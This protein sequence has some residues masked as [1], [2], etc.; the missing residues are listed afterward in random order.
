MAGEK[1][2]QVERAFTMS[3]ENPS[4]ARR[5]DLDALGAGAKLLG[6]VL[7]S[8]LSFFSSF[9]IVADRRQDAAFG[10][11]FAAIHGVR[12]PLLGTRLA[13]PGPCEIRTHRRGRDRFPVVDLSDRHGKGPSPGIERRHSWLGVKHI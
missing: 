5:S 10:V 2:K 9:W 3:A 12:M 8:S 13:N 6:I 4:L 11:V 7:H 1:L